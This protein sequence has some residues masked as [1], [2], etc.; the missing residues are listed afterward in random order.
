VTSLTS[1]LP[2]V[3][4][5]LRSERGTLQAWTSC[6][7]HLMKSARRGHQAH[8]AMYVSLTG[9]SRL[10]DLGPPGVKARPGEVNA[11]ALCASWRQTRG[12]SNRP[13]K[14][15]ANAAGRIGPAKYASAPTSLLCAL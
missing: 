8:G 1:A 9:A 5:P 3:R 12:F 4:K 15:D 6:S 2:L 11:R 13:S 10:D 7:T 14:S